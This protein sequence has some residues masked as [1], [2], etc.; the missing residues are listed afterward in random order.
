MTP[1][2]LV[3]RDLFGVR[4]ADLAFEG[5]VVAIVGPNGA[6]KSSL[7]DALLVAL[8]GEPSETRTRRLNQSGYVRVGADR[9]EVAFTFRLDGG[10]YRIS[11]TFFPERKAQRIALAEETEEGWTPLASSVKDAESLLAGLLDPSGG[12]EGR[13]IAALREAFCTSV[14]VPQGA[15]TELVDKTPADR[16]KVLAAALGLQDEQRFRER[17]QKVKQSASQELARIQWELDRLQRD[18]EGIAPLPTL[19]E[20]RREAGT[21]SDRLERALEGIRKA[22]KARSTLDERTR[23]LNGARHRRAR[24]ERDERRCRDRAS[25]SAASEGLRTLR[26]R[27]SRLGR[28][29]SGER[30]ARQAL[31]KEE[32]AFR[33]QDDLLQVFR[34]HYRKLSEEKEKQAPLARYASCVAE[35]RWIHDEMA[36]QENEKKRM[37]VEKGQIQAELEEWRR[38]AALLTR[39]ELLEKRRRVT[40]EHKKAAAALKERMDRLLTALTDWLELLAGDADVVELQT[41]TRL[42]AVEMA[43]TLA[44]SGLSRALEEI[45]NAKARCH[46]LLRQGLEL[47]EGLRDL[48]AEPLPEGWR[49]LSRE[50]AEE[51]VAQKEKAIR[52]RVARRDA[53][54]RE[55]VRLDGKRTENAR[56]LPDRDEA[57][58]RRVEAAAARTGEL[59]DEMQKTQIRGGKTAEKARKLGEQRDRSRERAERAGRELD[60]A[61]R[62]F[63]EAVAAWKKASAGHSWSRE[64]LLRAQREEFLSLEEGELE[65]AAAELQSARD[66]ERQADGELRA[67]R[68]E[69]AE[70]PPRAVELERT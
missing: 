44:D 20:R 47:H 38:A 32:G 62:L 63:D 51:K 17:A 9:G 12:E 6:G 64:E 3:I 41:L 70:E 22:E 35:I 48:P 66:L 42:R 37:D 33:E 65:R 25:L 45:T 7:L 50:Q 13:G 4:E 54:D 19:R 60:E 18:L 26:E 56:R 11:R 2:R 8:F 46:R 43:R 39:E 14:L 10:R 57:F 61:R 1:E 55:L 27:A 36:H 24:A 68:A 31:Q 59:D 52:D 5:G 15:V 28:A 30:E 69:H 16:W 21:R 58:L 23:R 53:A 67:F 49:T 34:D 40:A 29:R